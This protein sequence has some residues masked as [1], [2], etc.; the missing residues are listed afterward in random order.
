MGYSKLEAT[1]CCNPECSMIG[2]LRIYGCVPSP[3]WHA[4]NLIRETYAV[5]KNGIIRPTMIVVG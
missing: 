2:N 1:S 3:D 5:A 4:F